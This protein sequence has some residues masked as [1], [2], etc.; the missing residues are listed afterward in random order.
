MPSEA[1]PL[2]SDPAVRA[3]IWNATLPNGEQTIIPD[4][5]AFESVTGAKLARVL[6][7]NAVQN[8]AHASTEKLAEP[9]IIGESVGLRA[10]NPG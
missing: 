8:G 3:T 2:T 5:G 10:A 7:K 4:T 9:F 6:L 1:G